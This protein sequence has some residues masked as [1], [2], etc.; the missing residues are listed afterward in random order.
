MVGFIHDISLIEFFL[1]LLIL[2]LGSFTLQ[3]FIHKNDLTQEDKK[4]LSQ[5]IYKGLLGV[6]LLA[7]V[8]QAVVLLAN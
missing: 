1:I 8:L 7:V 3:A 6:T 2:V 4:F 5:L